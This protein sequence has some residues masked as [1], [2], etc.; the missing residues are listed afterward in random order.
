MWNDFYSV[1]TGNGC[2]HG[3]P[4]EQDHPYYVL[5]E[6]TGGDPAA[7]KKRFESTLAAA[8]DDGQIS[9]AVIAQSRQQGLDLWAIRDDIE[10]LNKNMW[11][12][13]VFDISLGIADMEDYVEAVRSQLQERWSHS[14][15]VV[16]GHL[17]DGNI[18]LVITLG[19]LEPDAVHAVEAIVYDELGRR[20]GVISAEHGIGL[21]KRAYLGHSRSDAEI[22]L[23]KTIKRALDPRNILNPG[24]I[25]EL[26]AAS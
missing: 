17:G 2:A 18:H 23:M 19:T 3:L 7:D 21:D 20:D 1:V 5:I 25:F 13:I 16:F 9:D 22:E 10:G 8:L 24:K 4:L 12:P 6:S 11:P 15:M 26:G 14:R